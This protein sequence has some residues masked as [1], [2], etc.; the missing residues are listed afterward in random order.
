MVKV[1]DSV[2]RHADGRIDILSWSEN[3]C[4]DR[5][6]LD[7][8][9][10]RQA[11]ELVRQIEDAPDR[12]LETGVALGGLV[13]DLMMDTPTV[14]AALLYRPVRA[15]ALELGRVGDALDAETAELLGSVVRMAST[16]ILEMSNAPLQTI[17]S[18]DQIENV[19]SM[20]VS[21]IDD[22]RVAVLKL[23]E[24]VVALRAAK[25]GPDERRQRIA[26]E[27]HLIFAPLANRLGIW[28]LKWELEDLALRYLEPEVYM[29]I[30]RRLDGRREER[31]AQVASVVSSLEEKL[32]A[33][34]IDA[35]V[36]G[37]AKHIFS[38][39]RKMRAKKVGFEEVYDVRAVRI[40]VPDIAQCY[41]SLGIVHGLWRHIPSEFD[42]YIAVPKENGYRSIHTAVM[43]PG[44][45]TLEVQIRTH[46]MHQESELGVCAH[47]DYKGG[48]REAMPYS[49]KMNW[50]RQVV[51]WQDTA[52][53]WNLTRGIESELAERVREER[54]F[55]YTPQGHV[56]DLTAGATPVDF[57]YRVHTEVGHSCCGARVDGRTVS[58]NTPL[59]TGQRVEIVTAKYQ[60][61]NRAWLDRKLGYVRTA[62]ARE[63]IQDWFRERP[64]Y[65]NR[66][67]GITMIADMS[68]RL[69]VAKP[70]SRTLGSVATE[71][72]LDDEEGLLRALAVG[73]CQIADVV[74]CLYPA[75][76]SA[77][78]M[79]LIPPSDDGVA[80]TYAVAIEATDREGLLRDISVLLTQSHLALVG[81]TGRVDPDTKRAHLLFELKLGGLAQLAVIVD[82]L[83]QIPDVID[84]RR[85]IDQ[86]DRE[87]GA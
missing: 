78:Q 72:G 39:Y 5:S 22:A 18:R 75:E 12:Y 48:D 2:P 56:L 21:M 45:G 77:R 27:A 30:A 51:D 46:E 66:A 37:R 62:R 11:A 40:I 29:D 85:V 47:W 14:C 76:Q 58:L 31:E 74:E 38:I 16:S 60:S 53:A 52:G 69:C 35:A 68:D 4:E 67:F 34:G 13:A 17:E 23:A 1:G 80:E 71:L 15:G 7:P 59:E 79:S 42:D 87:K 20:L 73:D 82:Q 32:R 8:A 64:D 63:Q 70:D 24:R 6:A 33:A 86:N 25:D 36:S 50:L 49:E 41:A 81:N 65:E 57:A 55:V 83:R 19:R 54:I 26:R 28:R 10:I 61:P 3:V 43:W 44:G 9:R 84:V